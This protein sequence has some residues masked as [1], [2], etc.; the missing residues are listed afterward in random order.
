MKQY[1]EAMSDFNRA[2]ELAPNDAEAYRGRGNIY[3]MKNKLFHA[4]DDFWKFTSLSKD[5]SEIEEVRL[6]IESLKLKDDLNE[7]EGKQGK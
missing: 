3:L 5:R 4:F 1:N 7:Q 6:Q 2:I